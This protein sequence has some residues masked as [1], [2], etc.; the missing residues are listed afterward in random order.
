M[1]NFLILLF[2]FFISLLPT[3]GQVNPEDQDIGMP[4]KLNVVEIK[5]DII[6]Q[7]GIKSASSSAWS[8]LGPNSMTDQ[9]MGLTKA[10]AV[11]MTDPNYNTIYVGSSNGGLWK[12]VNGGTNWSCITD[13][14]AKPNLGINCVVIDPNNHNILYIASDGSGVFK[15]IDGGSTWNSTGLSFTPDQQNVCFRILIDPTPNTSRLYVTV[16]T[17]QNSMVYRSVD[18]GSTFSVIYTLVNGTCWNCQRNLRDIKMKPYDP[19]T[20]YVSCDCWGQPAGAGGGSVIVRTT[21]AT[22]GT[23]AWTQLATNYDFS[24]VARIALAVSP[25]DPNCLFAT[26]RIG[27]T[28]YILKS[29]D[30]G[31]TWSLYYTKTGIQD[32][33][34]DGK[35]FGGTGIWRLEIEVS[36]TD[37]DVIYIGGWDVDKIVS[38]TPTHLST[39]NWITCH[40]D[41]RFLKI[42]SGSTQG[43]GGINDVLFACN[44]GGISKTVNGHTWTNINGT[45]LSISQ[46]WGIGVSNL[47]HNVI[48]GGTQD[49][50]VFTY[51]GGNWYRVGN[52]GDGGKTAFDRNDPKIIYNNSWSGGYHYI[53]KSKDG[54]RN[55][56][57]I[58]PTPPGSSRGNRPISVHETSL[59]T[60]NNDVFKYIGS[61]WQQISN[62]NSSFGDTSGNT[63]STF[64]VA[65]SDSNYIYATTG[66]N[67][68]GG[69]LGPLQWILFK[70]STAESGNP[71]WTDIS[72]NCGALAW[73]GITSIEFDPNNPQRVWAA[74]G[75][76]WGYPNGNGINRVNYSANGGISWTDISSG[77]PNL[78]VN[79]I[80]YQ[81]GSS[82]LLY[83]ATDGGVYYY[84]STS[85]AWLP[86]NTGFP[87]CIVQ[88]LAI[89]YYNG[90]IIAGTLGRGIWI[91]NLADPN[92]LEFPLTLSKS[93]DWDKKYAFAADITIPNGKTLTIDY[94]DLTIK[95]TAKITVESG[96]KLIISSANI[97][98]SDGS[99]FLGITVKNGGF[100]FITTST[101]SDYNVEV[102]SGGTLRISDNLT[103]TGSNH[104]D[105]DSGG[106]ICVN[107]TAAINL[108]DPLSF[109]NLH[110]GFNFGVNTAFITYSGTCI[111]NVA[112]INKTGLGSINSYSTDLYIQNITI[113]T[114]QYF[115]GKNIFAGSNVTSANP[116]GVGNVIFQSGANIIFDSN[117]NILLDKGFNVQ[118]GA[119][120]QTIPNNH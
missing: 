105:I 53:Q 79:K 67:T 39:D 110:Y 76:Y 57:T 91:S 115:L 6:V 48:C 28:I 102:Q 77:L 108:H 86:F 89:D 22:A 81:N 80:I 54:G 20:L 95:N 83:A 17:Q 62:F 68:N 30:S 111:S 84:N 2:L 41:I 58:L 74:F 75:G 100:L 64:S 119:A 97:V 19:N 55:S 25:K 33:S 94:A 24:Q 49:D 117:G 103:I 14:I 47:N 66:T 34:Y 82:D 87:N 35:N 37:L 88:D 50:N 65:P 71:V 16:G 21:N 118:I 5:P 3:Y 36:P 32:L 40:V 44:D 98:T 27:P 52:G 46:Y 23:P 4:L 7:G 8:F 60:A 92:Y 26:Y 73:A 114:S 113:S 56:W 93:V 78:P 107:N 72:A 70:T 12:T 18:G 116:P 29:T 10:V 101:L 15:S 42:I 90:Q 1:R 109:I 63:I 9:C 120:F 11:D 45:G 31:S 112:S 99:Q 13:I 106:F 51:S 85:N 96:G 61:S 43:N 59:Y 38:L 69:N 104:I